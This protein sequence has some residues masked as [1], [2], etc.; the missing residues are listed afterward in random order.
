MHT[1]LSADAKREYRYEFKH[2]L[3][4]L[5]T[6]ANGSWNTAIHTLWRDLAIALALAIALIAVTGSSSIR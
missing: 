6:V 3:T 4:H 5:A 1:H 2:Q